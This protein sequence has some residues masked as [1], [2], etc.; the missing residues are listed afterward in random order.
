MRNLWISNGNSLEPMTTYPVALGDE[1]DSP[2]R[3]LGNIER[4]D[5]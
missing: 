5:L 2:D 3:Y 4:L 1:L